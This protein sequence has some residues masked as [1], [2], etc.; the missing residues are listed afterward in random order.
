M[1][2]LASDLHSLPG[3]LDD[4]ERKIIADEMVS[5]GQS[6]VMLYN[7]Q[8]EN[9]QRNP[10]EFID[11]LVNGTAQP[12][13]ALD[14]LRVMGGYFAKGKR[15]R[16]KPVETVRLHALGE[17][18][19]NILRDEVQIVSAVL[20]GGLEAFPPT[21]K[22][23]VTAND[24]RAEV[25]SLWGDISLHQQREVVRNLAIDMQRVPD[26]V[27]MIGE[28]G[29]PKATQANSALAR[30]LDVNKQRPK[31]TLEFYRFVHGYFKARIK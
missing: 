7:Q 26:L 11:Q 12:Q 16:V 9:K 14:V 13:S 18:S 15:A 3:G 4:K 1:T 30:S 5:I 22:L 25:E 8:R 20:R 27:L 31:S 17:R 10:D 21:R 29:D 28:R 19:A 6:I 24:I 2:A 23:T